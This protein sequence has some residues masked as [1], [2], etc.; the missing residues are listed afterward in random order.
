MTLS[1]AIAIERASERLREAVLPKR[2]HLA[3]ALAKLWKRLK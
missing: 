2:S 3:K 1:L